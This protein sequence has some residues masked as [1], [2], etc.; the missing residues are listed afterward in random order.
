M[1]AV[2]VRPPGG[3]LGSRTA[4]IPA[5]IAFAERPDDCRHCAVCEY[6]CPEAAISVASEIVVDPDRCEGCG[7]CVD[8]CLNAVLSLAFR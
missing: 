8:Q 1:S 5:M 3:A 7:V 6:A 2:L 4:V